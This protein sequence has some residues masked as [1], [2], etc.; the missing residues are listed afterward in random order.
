MTVEVTP[1]ANDKS[2]AADPA[3]LFVSITPGSEDLHLGLVDHLALDNGLD[4]SGS[5]TTDIDDE[6]RSVPWDIGADDV[7]TTVSYRF[8]AP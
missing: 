2:P 4:L 7:S 3:D 5:F 1:G 6:L 8:I